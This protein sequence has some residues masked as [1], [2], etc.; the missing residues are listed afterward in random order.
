MNKLFPLYP[1]LHVEN[2]MIDLRCFNK[3][4]LSLKNHD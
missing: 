1:F 3:I 2:K 4:T